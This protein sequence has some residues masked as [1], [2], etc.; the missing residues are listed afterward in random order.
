MLQHERR[1]NYGLLAVHGQ[2]AFDYIVI[3]G[4]RKVAILDMIRDYIAFGHMF[5]LP[6]P[7]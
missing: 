2:P 7:S 3:D 6:N 4:T 1:R 5:I